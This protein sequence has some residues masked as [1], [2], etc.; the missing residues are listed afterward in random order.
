MLVLPSAF[1]I[2]LLHVEVDNYRDKHEEGTSSTP[3]TVSVFLCVCAGHR[4][5]ALRPSVTLFPCSVS[6]G[7][8]FRRPLCL[9][10]SP[11]SRQGDYRVVEAFLPVPICLVWALHIQ[12]VLL[13]GV[14]SPAPPWS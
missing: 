1:L 6:P 9:L 12:L 7:I 10:T 11:S 2:R 5:F 3:E 13:C 8:T 14:N 4:L